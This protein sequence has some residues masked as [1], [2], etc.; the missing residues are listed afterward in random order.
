[1]AFNLLRWRYVNRTAARFTP[2]LV[3]A[4][5][6]APR[7][8]RFE[9]AIADGLGLLLNQGDIHLRDAVLEAAEPWLFRPKTSRP[10]IAALGLGHPVGLK[11]LLDS[12][13]WGERRGDHAHAAA[14]LNAVNWLFQRNYD[15]H[16][17]MGEVLL[18]RLLYLSGPVLAFGLGLAQRRI[19][20]TGFHF[21]PATLLRFIDDAA[22]ERPTLVA[23]LER[24]FYGGPP[25]DGA[26]L[27]ARLSEFA[28]LHTPAAR[29]ASLRHHLRPPRQRGAAELDAIADL[30][31]LAE[32]L[33]L[34]PELHDAAAA[35][36]RGVVEESE[37]I[38]PA[39]HELVARRGDDLPA[40]LR[41]HYLAQVKDTPHLDP[42]AIPYW[43]SPEAVPE[44]DEI[45]RAWDLWRSALAEVVEEDAAAREALRD[46]WTPR[47]SSPDWA[48]LEVFES[49]ARE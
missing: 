33:L 11:L 21:K 29:Q 46:L 24:S 4:M 5:H 2:A 36:L 17:Q 9:R 39:I 3:E 42:D 30:V 34:V 49:T 20:G 25:E 14:C 26:E 35:C 48:A 8:V 16:A 19:S 28:A 7:D 45:A 10:L 31:S 43:A 1:L 40:E 6:T 13:E 38:P 22:A 23:D 18:Y 32:R 12:A 47:A 27:R 37:E 15:A 44:V 41:R